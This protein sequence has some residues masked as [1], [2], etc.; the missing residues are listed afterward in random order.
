MPLAQ[1]DSELR[2]PECGS[3]GELHAAVSDER[4]R[5]YVCAVCSGAWDADEV[6]AEYREPPE[7][8]SRDEVEDATDA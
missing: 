1:L 8:L 5:F 6:K 4:E 2:C 3:D 7:D